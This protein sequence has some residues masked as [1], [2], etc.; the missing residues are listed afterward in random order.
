MIKLIEMHNIKKAYDSHIVFDEVSLSIQDGDR[1]AIIGRSGSGKSTL[2]NIIGL[3]DKPTSGKYLLDGKE[4]ISIHSSS[5]RKI[6]KDKI[7]YLF[8][9]YAL[10]ENE[11]V[12]TNMKLAMRYGKYGN[13]KESISEA[14]SLVGLKHK[15]KRMIHTLS[16]GEQQRVALARL[17]LKP[18]N[19][20][21][22][23]EPTGNLDEDNTE[24]ILHLLMDLSHIGKT[25]VMVTHDHSLLHHFNKVINLDE[26]VPDG[27]R[28]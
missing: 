12:E 8:Q 5:A 21:L 18:C 19:I 17:L 28:V 23:D 26:F 24:I 9:N 4:N 3:L 27:N 14:L 15:E 22:A 2:L 7:G 11:T 1:V 25:V 6:L 10:L 20:I 13:K 16:G